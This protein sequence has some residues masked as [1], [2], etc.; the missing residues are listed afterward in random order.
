[1]SSITWSGNRLIQRVGESECELGKITPEDGSETVVLWLKDTCGLLD[2]NG[3]YIR[4]EEYASIAQAKENA[5]GTSSAFIMHWLWMR[6]SV[7]NQIADELE[8]NW[9]AIAPELND[10]SKRK[11]ARKRIAEYLDAMPLSQIQ[12]WSRRISEGTATSVLVDLLRKA[13]GL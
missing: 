2:L 6:N 4:A 9:D 12:N 3:G 13:T 7:K 10:N 1:M 11:E 5:A 8:R